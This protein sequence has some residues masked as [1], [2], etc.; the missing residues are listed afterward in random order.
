MHTNDVLESNNILKSGGGW[1][2]LCCWYDNWNS[3]LILCHRFRLKGMAV[4]F[5][6]F[7]TMN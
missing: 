3:F 5:D 4:H 7:D 1:T 6:C 2:Q